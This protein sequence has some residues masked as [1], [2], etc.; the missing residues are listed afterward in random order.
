MKARAR[1][2]R[3]WFM[4]RQSSVRAYQ[5]RVDS[6]QM[7]EFRDWH[8]LH[9]ECRNELDGTP[10]FGDLPKDAKESL[11]CM[12]RSVPRQNGNPLASNGSKL[13]LDR[14]QILTGREMLKIQ[15][16]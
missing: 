12:A 14:Q 8:T 4:M 10:F 6:Q 11:T 5:R 13:G 2:E 3:K 15:S 7:G 1:L 16:G 9:T